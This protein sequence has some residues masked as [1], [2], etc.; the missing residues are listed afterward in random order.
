[1]K[2]TDFVLSGDD[3]HVYNHAFVVNVMLKTWDKEKEK[4]SEPVPGQEVV[5]ITFKK[6]EGNTVF[7]RADL[8]EEGMFQFLIGMM[9]AFTHEHALHIGG[10]GVEA[11]RA[12][13]KTVVE[14]AY[15]RFAP[16]TPVGMDFDFPITPPD[17]NAEEQ[18]E[19]DKKAVR[20]EYNI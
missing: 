10:K 17:T 7:V 4:Y 15:E 6:P 11:M 9:S 3:R 13:I 16:L 5:E 8:T 18:L 1:M 2:P 20:E 12:A 14:E 19:A